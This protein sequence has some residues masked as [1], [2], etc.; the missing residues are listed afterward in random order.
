MG[1][2]VRIEESEG[3]TTLF[4][5]DHKANVLSIEMQ[6]EI[7]EGLNVAE[8]SASVV[9]M[10]GRPGVF[11]GGFDLATLRAGGLISRRM[12]E[13]GFALAMRMMEF[14]APIVVACTGHAIAMGSFLMLAADYRVGADGPFK[15]TAN[16]VAIGM[17]LPW[18]A[19]E[20]C[21]Y[22]LAPAHFDRAVNLAEVFAPSDAVTAG[23]LDEIVPPDDV[24]TTATQ[25]AAS[26][27]AL[28]RTAHRNTKLR[29][30]RDAMTAIALAFGNDCE[31]FRALVTG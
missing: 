8:Q 24:V 1:E 22:R 16:E 25:R 7:G 11:S 30:R 31:D 12:L 10:A 5:D 9:V 26:F 28:D 3:I 4:L 15:I 23:W 19:I 20:L 18:T 6:D 2:R 29:T 21:R 14:D 13:G 17:T 27:A